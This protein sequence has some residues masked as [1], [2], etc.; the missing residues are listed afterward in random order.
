MALLMSWCLLNNPSG[1]RTLDILIIFIGCTRRSMGSSKRQGLGMNAF[2]TS[3]LT[4]ASRSG[5]WIQLYSQESSMKSYLYVKFMLMISF[6]V[7]LTPIF[8]KNLEKRW[9]GNSRCP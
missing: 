7:Q 1:L 2:V 9:L 5:E 8:A 4:R 3:F 6:L